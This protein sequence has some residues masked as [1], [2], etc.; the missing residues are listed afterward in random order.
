MCDMVY[1]Q[2]VNERDTRARLLE[3]G[4]N[5]AMTQLLLERIEREIKLLEEQLHGKGSEKDLERR[6]TG[7]FVANV[8]KALYRLRG[9]KKRGDSPV[10]QVSQSS[11]QQVQEVSR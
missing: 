5:N 2:L 8:F 7:G 6:D 10:F 3:H 11:Q 1:M 4:V 9:F